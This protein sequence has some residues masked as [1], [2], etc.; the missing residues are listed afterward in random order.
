[1]EKVINDIQDDD[2]M[3]QK[4]IMKYNKP[5][6]R[7]SIWQ[8]INSVVPYALTWYLLYRSLEYPYWCTILLSLPAAGFMIRIFIIF[9]DC[10]HKAFFKSQRANNT[11]GRIM[12][13]L[14]FT[15]FL[16]WHNQHWIHHVTS[17][18]LDKRGI[19]DVWTLTVE[20]YLKASGWDKF[21]YRAFRNPFLMFTLGP[22]IVVFLTNR[23]TKKSM[24]KKEKLDIY[25]TNAMILLMCAAI[26][27]VIGLKAFLLIQIPVVLIAHSI[28][29]W[30][31][32]IQHQYDEVMWVRD[33]EW[34][35][36]NAALH[37]SSFLKLPPVLQWFTGNIGFH[38]VHHLSPKIPNYN[39]AK[40]HYENE[41][42]SDI[43]PVKLF[44]AYRALSLNLWDEVNMRMIGFSQIPKT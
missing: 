22:V 26:S 19:G 1:M 29:I 10:G 37:G 24:Q 39:L 20:E 23:L 35:Y 17:A 18:N 32:Y 9:H 13:I 14:A 21:A 43:Q 41:I 40:C 5:D 11:V 36:K 28:G 38:H 42:F 31:F 7:K 33:S 30:L 8:I 44:S 6:L 2:K 4:I 27:L 34:K 25:F 16:K 12:G 15:P 3:W